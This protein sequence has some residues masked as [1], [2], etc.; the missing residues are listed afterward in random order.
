M[1]SKIDQ[2][3]LPP[4][5]RESID[6]DILNRAQSIE[7]SIDRD[8][9][10]KEHGFLDGS[11]EDP[12]SSQNLLPK[13]H[14]QLHFGDQTRKSRKMVDWCESVSGRD[15]GLEPTPI[16]PSLGGG[17]TTV[18]SSMADL[19]PLDDALM[20]AEGE[21]AASNKS[22]ML[23]QMKRHP[24]GISPYPI[25]R[26]N[27]EQLQGDVYFEAAPR[28]QPGERTVHYEKTTRV[29]NEEEM[30]ALGLDPKVFGPNS[31]TAVDEQEVE[32]IETEVLKGGAR[33]LEDIYNTTIRSEAGEYFDRQRARSLSPSGSHRPMEAESS[34]Q[35][36]TIV[37][38]SMEEMEQ[39][40]Q[41]Y[42]PYRDAHQGKVSARFQPS[43]DFAAHERGT[44]PP[45]L[46]SLELH[47][48]TNLNQF[49]PIL[50]YF[51]LPRP[52]ASRCPETTN[53]EP[54]EVATTTSD[55]GNYATAS[56]CESCRPNPNRN[57]RNT[58]LNE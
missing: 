48:P 36:K 28:G 22:N 40:E 13:T 23:G 26:V 27:Q 31:K 43:L 17:R 3:L 37:F 15:S 45:D 4:V 29:L 20:P 58:W 30:D 25:Y 50:K 10:V 19:S 2:N 57:R 52:L 12:L 34:S 33:E 32:T 42:Y 38:G 41:E 55:N 24:Q 35:K 18:D 21:F 39:H 16:S 11:P 54:G 5:I 56:G 51:W 44:P 6:P 14:G 7:W 49:V 46:V 53:M 9:G 47:I 8:T 1:R